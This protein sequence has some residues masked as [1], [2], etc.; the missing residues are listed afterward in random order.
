MLAAVIKA[1]KRF[2]DKMCQGNI[3]PSTVA[4][5]PNRLIF[6]ADDREVCEK[7]YVNMLGVAT[8]EGYKS[9][10]WKGVVENCAGKQKRFML[11]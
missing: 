5:Y 1:R 10:V 7:S 8:V 11:T 6:L 4:T 2:E 3:P 9:K